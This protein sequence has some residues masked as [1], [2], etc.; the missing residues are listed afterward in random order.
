MKKLLA[1]PILIMVLITGCSTE[2]QQID[3]EHQAFAMNDVPE[4]LAENLAIPWSIAKYDETFYLTEREGSIVKVENGEIERQTVH[5]KKELATASEAGLL[6]LVLA[7]DFSKSNTAYAY[8][9][10]EDSSGQFNRIVTLR[11]EKNA[12][13][14]DKLLLDKIPSGPRHHGG[15]LKIGPDEKLYATTGDASVE[16]IAQDLTSLGGKILRMNLD[17]SLPSDNPFPNSYVYSYGLRNPQGITWSPDGTLYSTDHGNNRNDEVNKIEAGLNYGWPIIEGNEQKEGLVPPLFTSGVEET[18][19]PSGMDY[20]DGNLYVGALRG[21]A[22]LQFNLE[23]GEKQEIITSLGRIRDVLIEGNYL[24]FISNNT[25][26]RGA[27]QPNDDKLYRI[28][29]SVSN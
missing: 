23:T 24:Y 26:G 3:N 27:P 7:P 28:E 15:R 5:F 9:T 12:W 2:E 16:E 4:V 13:T 18:W 14:E 19:A 1:I 22:L 20:E 25:D 8:Y 21:T 29:L 6:G 11:L 10:Y 17:G